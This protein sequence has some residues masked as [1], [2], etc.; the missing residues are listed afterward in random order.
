MFDFDLDFYT[1]NIEF[2]LAVSHIHRKD[3]IIALWIQNQE[4][5]KVDNLDGDEPV[6]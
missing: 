5:N 1:L 3:N 4:S 6:S 2:S